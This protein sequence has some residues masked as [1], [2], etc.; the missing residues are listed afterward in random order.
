MYPALSEQRLADSST[1]HRIKSRIKMSTQM[2]P[3]QQPCSVEARQIIKMEDILK[4][5]ASA[6]G[7]ADEALKTLTSLAMKIREAGMVL[8]YPI[9]SF[10]IFYF[11][12]P[13][14]SFL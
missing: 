13:Q 3:A 5:H 9:L 6:S 8:L 7:S 11:F 14:T 4:L 12:L 10:F 2:S 1:D